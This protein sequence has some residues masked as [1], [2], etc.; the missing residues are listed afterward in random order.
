MDLKDKVLASLE[1]GT[2][3]NHS[4]VELARER[5]KDRYLDP[6]GLAIFFDAY[7]RAS[8]SAI[9]EYIRN[10]L[11]YFDGYE[12][13]IYIAEFNGTANRVALELQ[14]D[15][16]VVARLHTAEP[17]WRTTEEILR[18]E[19]VAK[20]LGVVDGVL[21]I[22]EGNNPLYRDVCE[23]GYLVSRKLHHEARSK[24]SRRS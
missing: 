16:P 24:K 5:L 12:V 6:F 10:Y 17:D 14:R 18:E 2:W 20:I 22:T 1:D 15:G 4:S 13:V 8:D 9:L 7:S 19:L 11:D 21:F 3:F 23:S